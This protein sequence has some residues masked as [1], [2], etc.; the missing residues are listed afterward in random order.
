[1]LT[2]YSVHCPHEDCGWR[3]CLFPEGNRDDWRPATPL[4]HEII[5]VCPNCHREW[6][7]RIVGEDV[8]NLPLHAMAMH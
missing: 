7:A 4:R 8:V 1:M 2:D 3:G 5:F 6:H